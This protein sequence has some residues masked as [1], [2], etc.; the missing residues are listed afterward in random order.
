MWE[1][2]LTQFWEM[3]D[4]ELKLWSGYTT[5]NYE[6]SSEKDGSCHQ[7]GNDRWTHGIACVPQLGLKKESAE[8]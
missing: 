7:R 3:A 8:D 6:I 1:Q 5:T 2:S 4:K